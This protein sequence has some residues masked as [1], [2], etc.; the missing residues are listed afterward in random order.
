MASVPYSIRPASDDGSFGKPPLFY[1][2]QLT[3]YSWV[4][5]GYTP[6]LPVSHYVV[7]YLSLPPDWRKEQ[8]EIT[9]LS[10]Y[11]SNFVAQFLA[12]NRTSTNLGTINE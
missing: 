1:Q 9:S 3:T 12:H 10:L 5:P 2:M 7:T 6:P 4:F 8:K 11:H